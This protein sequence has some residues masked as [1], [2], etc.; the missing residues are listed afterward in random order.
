M[1]GIFTMLDMNRQDSNNND[2]HLCT[3]FD[4]FVTK[5]LIMV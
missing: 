4:F 2:I 5:V 1:L 3:M